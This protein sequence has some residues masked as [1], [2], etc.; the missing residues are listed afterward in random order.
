MA[1]GVLLGV[2]QL[3]GGT[4]CEENSASGPPKLVW[5]LAT[6]KL[7]LKLVLKLVSSE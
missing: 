1:T 5:E 6:R 3:H 2:Q 4:Q 7:M